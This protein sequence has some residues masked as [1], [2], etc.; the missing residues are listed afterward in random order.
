MVRDRAYI[1]AFADEDGEPYDFHLTDDLKS[2]G[3]WESIDFRFSLPHSYFILIWRRDGKKFTPTEANYV[4]KY[5]RDDMKDFMSDGDPD[6]KYQ[7]KILRKMVD[8]DRCLIVAYD[9]MK[10][11]EQYEDWKEFAVY[12][13]EFAE[14]Q[15]T[16]ISKLGSQHEIEEAIFEGRLDP[17]SSMNQLEESFRMR[18]VNYTNCKIPSDGVL[19]RY[20]VKVQ[21]K[22][23]D[24]A[25]NLLANHYGIASPSIDTSAV[26]PGRAYVYYDLVNQTIVLEP[27]KIPEFY[28]QLPAFLIGF[29]RYMAHVKDWKF[30]SEP[31]ESM[32]RER[33]EAERFM[34]ESIQRLLALGLDPRTMDK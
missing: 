16:E 13:K 32:E 25:G 33:N 20:Y 26:L 10:L 11:P 27:S 29:F 34:G 14:E 19:I 1:M 5:I 9:R 31:S 18:S 15:A 7:A 17:L 4:A 28:L 2:H 23:F 21:S 22:R 12:M 24:E 8:S 30:S 6:I 3:T